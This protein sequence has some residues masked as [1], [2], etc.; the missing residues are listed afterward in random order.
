MD[1]NE[2]YQ[3]GPWGGP[4]TRAKLDILANYLNSYTTALKLKTFRLVYIDAFAGQGDVTIQTADN[5]F[6]QL[7]TGSTKR[8]IDIQDKPFDR[9]VFVDKARS[10][11]ERLEALRDQHET[12]D[13]RIVQSD[14]NDYLRSVEFDQE[15]WRGVLFID[16]FATQLEWSTLEHVA[17]LRMFDTW[18]L[19]PTMAVQRMLVSQYQAAS[20]PR[21][22]QERLNRIYGD[23]SWR[24]LYREDPQGNLFDTPTM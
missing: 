24:K 10:S 7:I 22:L 21:H 13:I 14:A 20:F 12:R 4:W 23:Q 18:I 1:G 15:S 16:P 5:D 19:F 2:I 8:A 11:C 3:A 17:D 9:L 6:N